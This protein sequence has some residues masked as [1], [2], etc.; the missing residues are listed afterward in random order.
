M[1]MVYLN[2]CRL[3]SLPIYMSLFR[4]CMS[5]SQPLMSTFDVAPYYH[6]PFDNLQFI[7]CHNKTNSQVGIRGRLFDIN[8]IQHT[9]WTGQ[10]AL[11]HAD[12]FVS[13]RVMCFGLV[14]V[15][16][17]DCRDFV[18]ATCRCVCAGAQSVLWFSS[19]LNVRMRISKITSK[20]IQ[21]HE[22]HSRVS[23]YCDSVCIY[24]C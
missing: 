19:T 5:K 1:V 20:P 21:L 12:F 11:A 24:T 4:E 13:L 10:T 14:F 17:F 3:R 16:G 15:F 18:A 6:L 7:L 2:Y 9:T 22:P 23:V 8:S